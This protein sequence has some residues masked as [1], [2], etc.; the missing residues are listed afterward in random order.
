MDSYPQRRNLKIAITVFSAHIQILSIL[1][2]PILKG[3]IDNKAD[4]A[5]FIN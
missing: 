2:K 3:E 4:K 1:Q 5:L